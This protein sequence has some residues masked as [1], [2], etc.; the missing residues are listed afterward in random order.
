M[1]IQDLM[2]AT[3]GYWN[4]RQQDR[5]PNSPSRSSLYGSFSG[6]QQRQEDPWTQRARAAGWKGPDPSSSMSPSQQARRFLGRWEGASQDAPRGPMQGAVP[7]M[8]VSVPPQ[9]Q[10]PT[11]R[12]QQDQW[13]AAP[14]PPQR[15]RS[16]QEVLAG[17]TQR[18]PQQVGPDV[19]IELQVSPGGVIGPGGPQKPSY[20]NLWSLGMGSH[21]SASAPPAAQ[22]DFPTLRPG[23][24][25]WEMGTRAGEAALPTGP[26]GPEI[27]SY[28]S[29]DVDGV[30]VELQGATDPN[31]GA[32]NVTDPITGEVTR[33]WSRQAPAT[34]TDPRYP[35]ESVLHS[36]IRDVN[37][38]TYQDLLAAGEI[39]QAT[40]DEAM[41][42]LAPKELADQ[43]TSGTQAAPTTPTEPTAPAVEPGKPVRQGVYGGGGLRSRPTPGQF[44]IARMSPEVAAMTQE[45]TEGLTPE[46]AAPRG[47]WDKINEAGVPAYLRT[48]GGT[49][50]QEAAKP[51]G[52]FGGSLGAGLVAGEEALPGIRKGILADKRAAET[53]AGIEAAIEG[54]TP[55]QAAQVRAL[56]GAEGMMFAR[57]LKQEVKYSD[58]LKELGVALP[59]EKLRA[60]E[61]MPPAEGFAALMEWSQS[62]EGNKARSAALREYGVNAELATSIGMDA[63]ITDAILRGGRGLQAVEDNF[64]VT[65]IV[66]LKTGTQVGEA[67]G[68]SDRGL[69]ERQ[70][71]TLEAATSQAGQVGQ[72]ELFT[73]VVGDYNDF[74]AGVQGLTKI[75][76]ALSEVNS[77]A[78][79]EGVFSSIR[80]QIGALL[81]TEEADH[82]GNL[83][84]I[85]KGIGLGNLS[86]FVGAISER[87]LAE[88]LALAG[89]VN[90]MHATLND[91]LA[92]NMEGVLVNANEHNG[93]VDR[94]GKSGVGLA[95]EWGFDPDELKRF[96]QVAAD[97]RAL[98]GNSKLRGSATY[99]ARMARRGTP[100]G[101][102]ANTQVYDADDLRPS[103]QSDPEYR[104]WLERNRK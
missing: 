52:T 22:Q 11:L 63:A 37:I 64:G 66:D 88:A 80:S 102:T 103:N 30:P 47:F 59:P 67:I 53:T 4:R 36:D 38:K 78:I 12:P 100:V 84:N 39:D 41:R 55:E 70:I 48:L 83:E 15:P 92:R 32:R 95:D 89:N 76:E 94:L 57:T 44:D 1:A 101:G 85:L 34:T 86:L 58:A 20:P 62:N 96:E 82:L 68:E 43:V 14:Q 72:D 5:F 75:T 8:V 90:D 54:L 81:K 73:Q 69:R 98:G 29:A 3:G 74:R 10:Y 35:K 31:R 91:I 9:Q 28:I 56:G 97:A 77:G 7:G 2:R 45:Y 71:A 13:E 50:M 42:A 26:Q 21:P 87:E 104:A 16:F 24:D 51:G 33:D 6:R 19:P 93:R 61:T 17:N 46:A 18:Q 40:F 65:R 27:P 25:Q 23:Q 60:F 99:Q 49:M 79:K